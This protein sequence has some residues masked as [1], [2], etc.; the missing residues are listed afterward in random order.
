M[1][2]M[3][4]VVA[5]GLLVVLAKLPWKMKLVLTSHPLA[6]DAI[7]FVAL[8]AIHWGT[9]SGVMVA[10]IGAF[11]CSIV[12]GLARRVIGFMNKGTYVRGFMDVSGR[13]Q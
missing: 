12:L 13:L 8:T 3:G 1:L 4:V 11:F 5:L 10:T 7:V 6:V 9:F 2:E